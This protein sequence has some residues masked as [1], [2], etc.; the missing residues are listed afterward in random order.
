[1]RCADPVANATTTT[2]P[3]T[4]QLADR[5]GKDW[6]SGA[7]FAAIADDLVDIVAES[8]RRHGIRG[9][10]DP[11]LADAIADAIRDHL[12]LDYVPQPV[13]GQRTL[14]EAMRENVASAE[15]CRACAVARESGDLGWCA[16][17][18]TWGYR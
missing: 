4:R 10:L 17:G 5:I 12:E 8:I 3:L 2:S 9:A 14:D 11:R 13:A 18:A 1:M 7:G 16:C 15:G 6:T